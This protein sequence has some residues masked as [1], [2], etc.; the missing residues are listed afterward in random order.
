MLIFYTIKN[1][2]KKN[3]FTN[4][5]VI[6]NKNYF[7]NILFLV[8][9]IFSKKKII[10]NYKKKFSQNNFKSKDGG[11]VKIYE[12]ALETYPDDYFINYPYENLEKKTKEFLPNITF[13]FDVGAN[14]GI[15]TIPKR[16]S[17]NQD[18]KF[19]CFEPSKIIHEYLTKN[20]SEYQNTYIYNC[21]LSDKDGYENLSL[22]LEAIRNG[23][24]FS[25]GLGSLKFKTFFFNEKV[26]TFKF[27]TFFKKNLNEI[28]NK[29]DSQI[30]IKVDIE[31]NELEFLNGGKEILNELNNIIIEMEFN[32]K[33]FFY[34]KEDYEYNFKKRIDILKK[35][36][37]KKV[38]YENKKKEIHI[39]N[40]L[41][42]DIREF[43]E[44][45]LDKKEIYVINF[46][47]VKVN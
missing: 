38:F 22:S 3:K 19:Y 40:L 12:N 30:L 1:F 34:L 39:I 47:F 25:T 21:A 45:K 42:F 15:W 26:Q 16:L 36:G 35:L 14:I 18:V 2:I 24:Y 46:F 33:S 29:K 4:F 6:L 7:R 11:N 43:F 10:E 32:K 37:F 28:V 13:I 44:K 20:L 8:K 17:F 27:D 5:L 41:D 9:F 23:R 31:G